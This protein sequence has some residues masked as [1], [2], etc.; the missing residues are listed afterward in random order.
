[1]LENS[2]YRTPTQINAHGFLTV[3]GAKM[4]KSRGTFITAQSYLESGL[5]PEWLRYYF[6]AKLNGTMED[7]DLNLED[8][9]ARVNSDLVGKY[10]NI[11]SRCAGFVTKFFDGKLNV[12]AQAS[13]RDGSIK[14]GQSVAAAFEARDYGK[15][16]RE[17]MA[18]ADATN[19]YVAMTAPWNVAKEEDRRAEL[20]TICSTALYDFYVISILLQPILPRVSARVAK[21]LF[22]LERDF[23]WDDLMQVPEHIN[24]YKHLMTRVEQKQVDAL[25]AANRDSLQATPPT[26]AVVPA[27][28]AAQ[29]TEEKSETISID[30]FMKVD[31]RVAKIVNAEHVEGADKLLKLTLSLGDDQRQVFA[32]IKSAYQPEQLIGRLTVMVANLAPRKM[33]FGMSE[34]MVLAAGPGGKDI[35]LLAPDE[36]STPGMKVK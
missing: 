25:V 19:A 36:G 29:P 14:L 1:M 5:N 28:T 34:G 21:E 10:I 17:I 23:Q 8:F 3:D 2:G 20:Q 22:G 30:D 16:I 31:L 27:K 26:A 15:A 11:A 33:K 4:S 18:A 35:F 9:I 32:G 24:I 12:D 6:A 7:I 13:R